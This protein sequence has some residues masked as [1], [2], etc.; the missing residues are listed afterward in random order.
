MSLT[1]QQL[2]L[3]L[4]QYC[5]V[6]SLD[7]TSAANTNILAA[8]ISPLL[9]DTAVACINGALQEVLKVSPVSAYKRRIMQTLEPPASVTIALTTGSATVVVTG[10]QAW[11]T[12]CTVLV[13]GDVIANEFLS[14][15]LLRRVWSGATASLQA[16]VYNDCILLTGFIDVP[17]PIE[18]SQIRRLTMCSSREEFARHEWN[19]AFGDDYGFTLARFSA[20]P[21]VASQP[22]ACYVDTE[23]MNGAMNRFLYFL[24]VPDAAYDIAYTVTTN[25]FQITRADVGIYN[26]PGTMFNIPGGWDESVLL[27][28][29]LKRFSATPSFGTGNPLIQ[30]E[31]DRQHQMAVSIIQKAAPNRA[32]VLI[33]CY[34]R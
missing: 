1:A 12:G 8:G 7:P 23:T 5:G 14:S 9:V 30:A 18:I 15:T 26:D 10:W 24:P 17:G 25:A 22:I 31:I 13:G 19:R 3:Q 33:N 6:T 20:S 21:K 29:A 11:M 2:V 4:V 27:P 16:T 32:P 28:M 34:F